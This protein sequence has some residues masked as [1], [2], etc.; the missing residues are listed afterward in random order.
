[1]NPLGCPRKITTNPNGLSIW[2]QQVVPSDN[3]LMKI[4]IADD[5]ALF[6]GGFS[7]LFQQLEG[8][9]EI[10]EA[11]NLG[12]AMELARRNPDAELM[13]LDLNMPGMNGP[14]SI[15]QISAAFPQLPLVVISSDETMRSVQAVIAAGAS[16]Y[17]PKSSSPA[18]MQHAIRLVLSGGVYLPPQMLKT[19]MPDADE[20]PGGS[21]LD[22]LSDR[23]REV[24]LLVVG[25]MST[26]QICRELGL[27][28]GTIKS[29]IAAIFRTLGVN[30][31]VEATNVA[32][33]MGLV[34]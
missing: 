9:A 23:Q 30:N 29:H 31:R 17:I 12:G 34:N 24:L 3:A 16:G 21:L 13:L 28:E 8:E 14:A 4:I 1:M 22:R 20:K 10:L 25:G 11:G 19:G 27:S 18:V 6:R 2:K 7:V 32:R 5:H 26:K 33:Q 15:E